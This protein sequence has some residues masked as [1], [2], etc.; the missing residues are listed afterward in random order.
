M[1]NQDRGGLR[2]CFDGVADYGQVRT[3]VCVSD[4]EYL[5]SLLETLADIGDF[6]IVGE[7]ANC[8][9]ALAYSHRLAPDLMIVDD[10]LGEGRGR[11][12]VAGL[13]RE[14]AIPTM[15]MV[16]GDELVA[17][18]GA[19]DSTQ[20]SILPRSVVG[21][22]DATA[23]AHVRTRLRLLAARCSRV[24]KTGGTDG[25]PDAVTFVQSPAATSRVDD[26]VDRLVA[27]PLELIVLLGGGGSTQAMSAMLPK[28]RRL[29]VPTLVA[30]AERDSENL[31]EVVS[32]GGHVRASLL[33]GP[34]D[35]RD[36]D[37]LSVLAPR[38]HAMVYPESIETRPQELSLDRLAG[39][40]SSLGSAVLVVVLSARQEDCVCGVAAAQEAGVKVAVMAPAE[41]QNDG[42]ARCLIDQELTQYVLTSHQLTQVLGTVFMN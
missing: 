6:E 11:D 4:E 13:A 19:V 14:R 32:K 28:L 25:G 30:I 20:V 33:D 2:R 16:D 40:T 36:L 26:S 5:A 22:G 1:G 24:G 8:G 23:R 3:L 41:V 21:R 9:D 29:A 12:V 34:C 42:A 18:I 27:E 15:L 7:A 31:V 10:A 37:G 35:L 38:T 17:N 39:S